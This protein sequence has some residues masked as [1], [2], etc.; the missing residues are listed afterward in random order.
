MQKLLDSFAR[1]CVTTT[2]T[3]SV[4][5]RFLAAASN[6]VPSSFLNVW[7]HQHYHSPL[8]TQHTRLMHKATYKEPGWKQIGYKWMVKEPADGKYTMKK[9][10]L[11]KL[12]GRD[13]ETGNLYTHKL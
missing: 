9:L 1:L 2:L 7:I 11:H 6:N 4:S 12:G 13:P 8:Q 10:P 5:N 3:S